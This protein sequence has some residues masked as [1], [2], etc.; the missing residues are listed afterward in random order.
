MFS[1]T[2]T[3]SADRT[4]KFWQDRQADGGV[5]ATSSEAA[6][7]RLANAKRMRIMVLMLAF[8]REKVNNMHDAS[9]A[10]ELYSEK[11]TRYEYVVSVILCK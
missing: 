6:A 9:W 8:V 11:P 7:M 3:R 10:F 2:R 1:N 4:A 5:G